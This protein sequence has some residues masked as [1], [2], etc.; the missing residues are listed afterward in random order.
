MA[1]TIPLQCPRMKRKRAD[2]DPNGWWAKFPL[3]TEHP[4]L[5]FLLL[6]VPV[7]IGLHLADASPLAVFIAAA[8]G[9]VIG[10]RSIP[11]SRKAGKYSKA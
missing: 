3:K 11:D 1:K 2:R 7:A 10:A 8:I 9:I 4:W 6:A 5:N